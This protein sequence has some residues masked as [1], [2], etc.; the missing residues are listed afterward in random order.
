MRPPWTTVLLAA[1]ALP[2]TWNAAAP[3]ALGSEGDVPPGCKLFLGGA[4][5]AA[6]DECVSCHRAA[7]SSHRSHPVD[8]DYEASRGG[9]APLRPLEEVVRRGV[10]VPEG[11]IRC[12]T[13][14]DAR[15]EWKYHLALPPGAQAAPAVNPRDPRTYADDDG[16]GPRP[17]VPSSSWAARPRHERAVSQ[18]PLCLACH[19]LD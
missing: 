1:V 2:V 15:S 14:H 13:C 18:K 8:V 7:A 12:A 5:S 9:S 19:G 17:A 6:A 3:A 11:K 4:E 10:L 16:S